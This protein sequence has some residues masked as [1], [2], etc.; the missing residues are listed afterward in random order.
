VTVQDIRPA[1]GA[2]RLTEGKHAG[3]IM[4]SDCAPHV[5]M[6]D[7]VPEVLVSLQAREKVG[8]SAMR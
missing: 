2:N 8:L 1:E 7:V 5:H 3:Q 6:R 4:C